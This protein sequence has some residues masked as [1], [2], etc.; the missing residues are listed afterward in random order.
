[1]QR[2]TLAIFAATLSFLP[3]IALADDGTETH[4]NEIEVRGFSGGDPTARGYF[5]KTVTAEVSLALS[6][7][8]TRGWDELTVG[9]TLY[10]TP[11]MS[12][13]AGFGVSRY[14][15]GGE[16]GK[17]AHRT[18]SAFW[19][20]QTDAWEAEALVERYA[21]DPAPWYAE[22]YVQ[23][24]INERLSLGLFAQKGSGWGPRLSY[25]IDANIAVWATPLAKSTGDSAAIVGV[26]VSF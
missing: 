5:E 11:E 6:A 20:W 16:S 3:H 13:G 24:W 7:F 10:L 12:V 19:F 25:A 15:A 23:K 17:S 22:G 26:M 4:R 21:R 18:M 9:P 1:M 8:K 14:A 2:R